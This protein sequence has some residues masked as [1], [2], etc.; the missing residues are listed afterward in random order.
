MSEKKMILDVTCGMRGIW[1]QKNEP[2]TIYCDRRKEHYESYYGENKAH[3]TI[4]VDPDIV[5]DFTDLPFKDGMFNLVVFDPPHIM[6]LSHESWVCKMYETLDEAWPKLL[7][8]GFQEC[9]RVLKV[10]GGAG[11]QMGRHFNPYQESYR[12][13]RTGTIIWP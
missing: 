13:H 9:M 6:N 11:V 2:H 8:D 10:G 1:F 3:R 12:S 7:R 4:E 5:C